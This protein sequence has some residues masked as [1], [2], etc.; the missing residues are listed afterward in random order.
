[1]TRR[2]IAAA[3]PLDEILERDW[4]RQVIGLAKQLGWQ[5]IYHTFD[6]RR[7][8]HGFPDLVL[9]GDR[10]IYL[11]L[12]REK[13]KLTDDQVGWLNALRAG[14]AEAYVARPRD[15]EALAACL[16]RGVPD[17]AQLDQTT[18]EELAA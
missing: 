7:S 4:Q 13:T 6:S 1:V 11:E 5:R 8:T 9:A 12:K 17:P 15:L 10:V 16:R 18:E 2:T 3:T 14:G